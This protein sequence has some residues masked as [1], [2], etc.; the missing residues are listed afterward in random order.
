MYLYIQIT[1]DRYLRSQFELA[2]IASSRFEVA[3]IASSNLEQKVGHDDYCVSCILHLLIKLDPRP[4]LAP[5]ILHHLHHKSINS[6]RNPQGRGLSSQ[7]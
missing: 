1:M 5:I 6:H 7:D 2:R 3:R 4:R